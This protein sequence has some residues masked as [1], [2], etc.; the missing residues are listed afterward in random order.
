MTPTIP[1]GRIG[2]VPIRVGLS[3]LVV[4][5]LVA[6][7]LFAG[8]DPD[9]A[10]TLGRVLVACAGT[11]GMFGSVV[12]HEAGHAL[13]ATHLGVR[14]QRIVLFLFGGYTEMETDAARPGAQ[15]AVSV[16]GPVLSGLL[17]LA[18]WGAAAVAPDADGF[19]RMLRLIAVVNAAVAAFNLLPGF[20]LDGGR[21]TRSLL[22]MS[23]MGPHRAQTVT[24][25]FGI[26][27]GITLVAAGAIGH[28]AGRPGALLTMPVGVLIIVLASAGRPV[29]LRTAAD[30]MRPASAP[31][32]E[33]ASIASIEGRVG[34]VPV[35]SSGRVVGLVLPADARGMVAEAMDPVLPG[36]VVGAA[37]P[38]AGVVDR[39]RRTG[40][41]LVVT[42]AD[43][44]ILGLISPKD[45]PSDL[46]GTADKI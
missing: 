13:V 28:A 20:P 29:D 16:A 41:T 43:G 26:A 17:A 39:V 22:V 40:R 31:V 24:T 9:E 33:S 8:I 44:T 37:M 2:G 35:V 19:A 34:P 21:I 12:V 46:L 3:W 27:I 45:L 36:D 1:L 38:L 25:W 15:A 5:P 42:G 14:V 7:L 23:G 10:S 30:V 6:A 18:F 32:G 4:M 11:I